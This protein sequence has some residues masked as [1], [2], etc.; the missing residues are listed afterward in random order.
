MKQIMTVRAPPAT[1]RVATCW[2]KCFE[3]NIIWEKRIHQNE[4]FVQRLKAWSWKKYVSSNRTKRETDDKNERDE[5]PRIVVAPNFAGKQKHLNTSD[6]QSDHEHGRNLD[7]ANQ[8][9]LKQE[10]QAGIAD[11]FDN[12][13]GRGAETVAVNGHVNVSPHRDEFQEPLDAGENADGA[14]GEKAETDVTIGGS[15]VL[16][17]S[18]HFFQEGDDGDEEW[19]ECDGSKVLAEGE[20][21][22]CHG[23]RARCNVRARFTVLNHKFAGSVSE[24]QIAGYDTGNNH[25]SDVSNERHSIDEGEEEVEVASVAEDA[26]VGG[27][28]LVVGDHLGRRGDTVGEK[29]AEEHH[30]NNRKGG[31]DVGAPVSRGGTHGGV[32]KGNGES[33]ARACDIDP[34]DVKKDNNHADDANNHTGEG[35]VG[36]NN[37]SDGDSDK[38]KKIDDDHGPD[39]A[40]SA[41]ANPIRPYDSQ[42]QRKT[43]GHPDGTNKLS[44]RRIGAVGIV[45]VAKA[46]AALVSENLFARIAG[47][48]NDRQ[49]DGCNEVDVKQNGP[50]DIAARR[51]FVGETLLGVGRHDPT[52]DNASFLAVHRAALNLK[53]KSS[54]NLKRCKTKK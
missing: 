50:E 9:V 47:D 40:F 42:T 27:V 13:L 39:D 6:A 4:W 36:P 52:F 10:L 44:R 32:D 45:G 20:F 25:Q 38:E 23:V 54:S 11:E 34:P 29:N 31:R 28:G 26:V 5:L 30:G 43:G 33:D 15:L 49:D 48:A 7:E 14:A 46:E 16:Q 3:T 18:G 35:I 24:E 12:A 17:S 2:C 51:V 53:V 37:T 19:A 22:A 21:G 41:L 1:G 8:L